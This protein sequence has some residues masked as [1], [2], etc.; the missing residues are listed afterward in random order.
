MSNFNLTAIIEQ[1][2][3][4]PKSLAAEL[5][6]GNAYPVPA[7]K[8]VLEGEALLNTDQISKLSFMTG[9]PIEHLF[10]GE[11]WKSVPNKNFNLFVLENGEFK[12]T[13]DRETW[14]TKIYH[15]NSIFHEAVI[16]DGNAVPMSVYLSE[17]DKLILNL[18]K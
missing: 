3:L 18:N 2:K 16:M 5:F 13:L 12:A 1:Y 6:P 15:K 17:L 14:V 9:I 8:R 7:L 4:E 11:K 10:T